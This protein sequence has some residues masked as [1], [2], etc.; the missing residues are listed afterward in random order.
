MIFVE[1][2]VYPAIVN[3]GKTDSHFVVEVFDYLC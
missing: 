1:T 3:L 2:E